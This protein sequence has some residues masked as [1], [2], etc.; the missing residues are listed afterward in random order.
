MR[1]HISITFAVNDAVFKYRR[2]VSKNEINVALNVAVFKKVTGAVDE[3]SILPTEEP[4]VLKNRA[5]SVDEEG[6]SL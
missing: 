4:A 5:L 6:N 1:S 2:G 3:Q